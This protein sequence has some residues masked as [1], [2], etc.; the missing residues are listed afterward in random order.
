MVM[1]L[2]LVL[3]LVPNIILFSKVRILVLNQPIKKYHVYDYEGLFRG[4]FSE[5]SDTNFKAIG[6]RF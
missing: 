6:H 4:V 3:A 1:A 2:T 5:R